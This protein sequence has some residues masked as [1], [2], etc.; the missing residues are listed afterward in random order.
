MGVRDRHEG[1]G[2]G[3]GRVCG[4]RGGP[5]ESVGASLGSATLAFEGVGYQGQRPGAGRLGQDL[6]AGRVGANCDEFLGD[7]LLSSILSE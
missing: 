5:A 6:R 1:R 2:S 7:K 3:G 4:A